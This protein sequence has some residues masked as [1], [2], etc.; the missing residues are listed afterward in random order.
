MEH[1]LAHAVTWGRLIGTAWLATAGVLIYLG[2]KNMTVAA[3]RWWTRRDGCTEA[4]W[5][6]WVEAHRFD[7]KGEQQ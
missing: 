7:G 6:E 2:F 1:A 5:A 3:V 4:E